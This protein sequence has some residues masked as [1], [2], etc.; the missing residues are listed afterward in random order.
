LLDEQERPDRE[1]LALI[2]AANQEVM[3][4]MDSQF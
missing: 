2:K 1:N 3:Q 4:R